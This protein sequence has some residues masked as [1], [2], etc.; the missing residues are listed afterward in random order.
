MYWDQDCAGGAGGVSGKLQDGEKHLER[1]QLVLSENANS[2]NAGADALQTA[3]P[4][5]Q[6]THNAKRPHHS[7]NT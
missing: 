6:A 1:S 2:P 4:A 3:R 5:S 7:H